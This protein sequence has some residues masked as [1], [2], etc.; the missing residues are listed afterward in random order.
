MIAK[1]AALSR[2]CARPIAHRGLHGC[3]RPGKPIENSIE[4]AEAAI[5]AG[6]GIECDVQLSADGEAMVFH[7]ETLE[8]LTSATG[9]VGQRTA[10]DLSALSLRN[11][12]AGIPT[13]PAF[14]RAIDGRAPLV[15]EIKSNAEGVRLAERVLSLLVDYAVV[16]AIESFDVGIVL[17]CQS[18]DSSCPIGLVGPQEGAND[19]DGRDL[20]EALLARCD[21]LSWSIDHLPELAARQLGAPLTTWTV[22]SP[23]QQRRA[24]SCRA[25]IVFEGFPP[26]T[27]P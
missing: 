5:A 11:S 10:S 8:R 22:R 21:F 3:G 15:I 19:V 14:L 16:A 13:L 17:Y 18:R 7:D 2:L 6:F 1:H 24:V 23:E 9:P 20:A 25:Q 26:L 12:K 4:A 27:E